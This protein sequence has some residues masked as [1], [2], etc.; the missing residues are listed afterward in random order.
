MSANVIDSH[1]PNIINNNITKNA[2]SEK[3]KVT[4][5]RPSFKKNEREKN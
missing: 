4:S 1:F 3:A 5:V 2:F